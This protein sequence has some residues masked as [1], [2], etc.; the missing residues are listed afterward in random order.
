MPLHHYGLPVGPHYKIMH[1]FYVAIMAP[2]GYKIAMDMSEYEYCGFAVEGSLPDFWLGG[3]RKEDGLQKY[4][5]DIK[6][7]VSPIHVAFKAESKEQVDEW[8]E[9]A[10]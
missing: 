9:N 8:Y 1:D 4:D 3:G 2:L 6:G 5:G 10:M 7:R